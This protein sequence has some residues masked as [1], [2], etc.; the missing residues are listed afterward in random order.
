MI[1][2]FKRIKHNNSLAKLK[3]VYSLKY[4]NIG[5]K[6]TITQINKI[7]FYKNLFLNNYQ[8]VLKL[9]LTTQIQYTKISKI[10]SRNR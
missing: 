9:S 5:S 7:K 10:L 2:R 4:L 8:H 1:T 6:M 3:K